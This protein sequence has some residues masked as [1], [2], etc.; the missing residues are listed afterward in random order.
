[1]KQQTTLLQFL[2]LLFTSSQNNHSTI[3]VSAQSSAP[4]SSGKAVPSVLAQQEGEEHCSVDGSCYFD[5]LNEDSS[6]DDSGDEDDEEIDPHLLDSLYTFLSTSTSYLPL[7]TLER[8][9]LQTTHPTALNY[10]LFHSGNYSDNTKAGSSQWIGSINAQIAKS[11]NI[12][13]LDQYWTLKELVQY[14]GEVNNE[15]EEYIKPCRIDLLDDHDEDPFRKRCILGVTLD[16]YVSV[17]SDGLNAD[18]EKVG[19]KKRVWALEQVDGLGISGRGEVVTLLDQVEQVKSLI[20]HCEWVPVHNTEEV[21]LKL[22][23]L[24]QTYLKPGGVMYVFA[25]RSTSRKT[26]TASFLHRT[27]SRLG[28][29]VVTSTTFPTPYTFDDVTSYLEEAV[30]WID[31]MDTTQQRVS[32][33]MKR[34]YYQ[35]CS[36]LLYRVEDLKEGGMRRFI[37]W[38]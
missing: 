21:D 37:R 35:L 17:V 28:L 38:V 33:E 9:H 32:Q 36:D 19:E 20:R 29:N 31:E 6:D 13:L 25:L 4:F 1:M 14:H 15:D 27:I 16:E 11:R 10:T 12:P 34:S 26:S 23:H 2:S 8:T 24:V 3:L 7:Q 22:E 18:A 30:E 5:I